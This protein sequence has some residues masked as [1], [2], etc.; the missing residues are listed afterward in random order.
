MS[1]PHRHSSQPAKWKSEVYS[2][3]HL[4]CENN[5]RN[6][7]SNVELGA[8]LIS[9]QLIKFLRRN[10]QHCGWRSSHLQCPEKQ[11]CNQVKGY[12]RSAQLYWCLALIFLYSEFSLWLYFFLYYARSNFILASFFSFWSWC[13]PS[14]WM[15]KCAIIFMTCPGKGF[16]THE[17]LN[18][19]REYAWPEIF[20]VY[21]E[22][23]RGKHCP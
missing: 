18:E 6:N 10:N 7:Q 20:A 13:W 5:D 2:A 3:W 8:Q 12:Y 11:R 23:R 17:C 16:T 22:S 19:Y 1:K 14:F 4:C 9:Y 21:V 15:R